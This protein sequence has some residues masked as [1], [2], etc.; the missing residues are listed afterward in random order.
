MKIKHFLPAFFWVV[1]LPYL[2]AQTGIFYGIPVEQKSTTIFDEFFV[3]CQVFD[4]ETHQFEG[5]LKDENYAGAIR[6]IT[7]GKYDWTIALWKHGL[8]GP[9]RLSQSRQ[10]A[11]AVS[12]NYI[13]QTRRS[14]CGHFSLQW[15]A[16]S[17]ICDPITKWS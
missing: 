13:R 3:D 17:F 11:G 6:L 10:R 4:L 2:K 1:L 16:H 15:K 8:R 12:R 14:A 9:V 7:G 5:Y